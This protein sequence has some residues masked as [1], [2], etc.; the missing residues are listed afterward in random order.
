MKALPLSLLLLSGAA[1][2]DDQAI[3]ACRTMT[4]TAAR[5]AC[6]DAIKVGTRAPA[7]PVAAALPARSKEENFGMEVAKMREESPKSVSSTVVGNFAGWGPGSQIRLANGQVWRIIDG[8]EAVL[9]PARDQKV[10]IERNMF[11][12]LFLKVEG[13]NSSAKVRRVQ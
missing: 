12:T 13:S 11:G 2:A 7:A 10:T 4:D 9:T 8:S 1:M 3:L 5:L 6:Y